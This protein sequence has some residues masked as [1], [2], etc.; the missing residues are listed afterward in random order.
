MTSTPNV[1][2]ILSEP[3]AG[4][5]PYLRQQLQTEEF[6]QFKAQLGFHVDEFYTQ[7]SS[8]N[9]LKLQTTL[10]I[11]LK[12]SIVVDS[13]TNSDDATFHA[14]EFQEMLDTE[15]INW[16][17]RNSRLLKPI[18]EIK[19]TFSNLEEIPYHG[20]YLPGFELQCKF[21][22]TYSAK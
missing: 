3:E 22:L 18:S 19:G 4:L 2:Q 11:T 8:D 5:L 17:Q 6:S 16:S 7:V 1:S 9:S 10:F 20:G 21:A 13:K 12:L 14:L 15:I